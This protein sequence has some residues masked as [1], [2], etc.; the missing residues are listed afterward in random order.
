MFVFFVSYVFV[1]SDLFSLC[2][3]MCGLEH[4][5]VLVFNGFEISVVVGN[6]CL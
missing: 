5:L 6:M 2:V 1:L 4:V 3:M